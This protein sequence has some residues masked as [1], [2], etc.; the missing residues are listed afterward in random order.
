MSDGWVWAVGRGKSER[1]GRWGGGGG[2]S[3][4][5]KATPDK[6]ARP[7]A[8]HEAKGPDKAARDGQ[9]DRQTD[10]QTDKD[11]VGSSSSPL[12]RSVP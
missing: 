8:Y 11:A 1:V 7:L 2:E 10:R 6:R 12:F 3:G 9:T 5:N 4:A